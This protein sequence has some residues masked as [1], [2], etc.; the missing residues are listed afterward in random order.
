[1]RVPAWKNVHFFDPIKRQIHSWPNEVKKELGG[2][3]TRLQKGESIGMPDVRP[4]PS[5]AP[6]VSE[7]RITDRSGIFRTFYV[8]RDSHG[9]LVFHAFKKKSQKTPE[10]E[11]KT[12]QLRLRIFLDKLEEEL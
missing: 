10:H 5:I 8:V 12:A 1:M 4:M 3:L 11:I 2:V 9:V 7:I 6:G